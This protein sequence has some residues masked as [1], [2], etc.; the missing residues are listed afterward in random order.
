MGPRVLGWDAGDSRREQRSRD[1][2]S[3]DK[4]WGLGVWVSGLGVWV[5]GLGFRV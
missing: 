4:L 2:E 5:S 1:L 3:E